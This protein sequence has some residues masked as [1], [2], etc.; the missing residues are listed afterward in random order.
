MSKKLLIILGIVVMVILAAGG[1]FFAGIS[2]GGGRARQSFFQG[3]FGGQGGQLQRSG[4][5]P[6]PGQ[7]NG[8]RPGGGIMG[9]IKSVEGDTVVVTTQNGDTQVHTSDTTLV[10]KFTAVSVGDLQVG[11]R[12][13]VTGSP[14]D[15]GSVT[16]RSIQSMRNFQAAPPNAP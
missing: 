16:A 11:E 4:R 15:D 13:V 10:E 6:Q 3:Q 8:G 9:T 14:N 2:L 7:G 5:T 12:V 1:G